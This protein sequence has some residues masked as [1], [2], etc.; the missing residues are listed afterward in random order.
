V[1]R[2]L[3]LEAVS[4]VRGGRAVLHNISLQVAPG[5]VVVIEGASGAG[6]TTLLHA[7]AGLLTYQGRIEADSRPAMVFQEHALAGRLTAVEN[8][9]VGTLGRVG[10]TR[11]TLRLW[12]AAERALALECLDRVGLGGLG[13]RRAAHLSGGQRQ[14]VAIARALAQRA[15]V[16]LADEPVASLDPANAEAVLMLLRSLAQTDGLAVLL[17]L[18]QPELARRFGDRRMHLDGGRII[19]S[20]VAQAAEGARAFPSY[21]MD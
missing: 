12:P 18:H 5:E 9:L 16:M 1:S 8:V 3:R 20:P 7:A 19:S 21:E 14:R 10:F 15:S 2:G 11:S 4:V 6:K 13:G 17:C